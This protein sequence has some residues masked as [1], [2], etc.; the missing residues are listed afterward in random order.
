MVLR[1]GQDNLI[2]GLVAAVA[3]RVR[4]GRHGSMEGVLAYRGARDTWEV[5][6]I[7]PFE[8]IGLTDATRAIGKGVVVPSLAGPFGEVQYSIASHTDMEVTAFS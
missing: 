5:L 2:A 8:Q 7:S 6:N 1:F 3:R 4:W